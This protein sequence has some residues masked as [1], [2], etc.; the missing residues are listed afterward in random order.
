MPRDDELLAL[1]GI[2]GDLMSR[3]LV[4]A[5]ARLEQRG[6]LEGVALLGLDRADLEDDALRARAAASIAASAPDVPEPVVRRLLDRLTYRRADVTGPTPELRDAALVHVALPPHVLRRAADTLADVDPARGRRLVVEKPYGTSGAEAREL[7]ATLLATTPEER[8]HRADHLLHHGA[9][10][11]VDLVHD[12]VAALRPRL[13]S[14]EVRWDEPA[15]L[16]ARAAAFDHVG[17]VRDMVQSH[18]LQLLATVLGACPPGAGAEEARDRRHAVLASLDAPPLDE[19]DRAWVRARYSA[20]SVGGVEVPAYVDE[21][22]VDPSR[23]TET[24]AVLLLRLGDV[25]VH[26]VTGKAVSP[27]RRHVVLE[28]EGAPSRVVL[29]LSGARLVMTE[30]GVELPVA[31]SREA[32]PASARQLMA[33]RAGELRRFVR[34]DEV[35]EQWRVCDAVLDRWQAGGV[36]MLEHP[37]GSPGPGAAAPRPTAT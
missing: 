34:G 36:P 13:R 2:A 5:L 25:D 23:L 24:A 30:D 11:D 10:L 7:D 3:H 22:G 35:A 26:L 12:R 8:L 16:G 4:P 28:L 19:L 21:P 33:A 18:L 1:V 37:A 17:A 32:L 29:D 31:G 15:A 6:D 14:V 27:V 20:G 9:V